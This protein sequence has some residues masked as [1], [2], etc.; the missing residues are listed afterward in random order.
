[1]PGHNTRSAPADV[2]TEEESAPG[3][4]L[5][6][7]A[8]ASRSALR[9]RAFRLEYV[10]IV[11]NSIEGIAAIAAGLLAGSVALVGFGLDSSVEVFASLAVVWELSGVDR[12]R[13]QTALRLIGTGYIVVALYVAWSAV[14]SL[15]S[16]HRPEASPLGMVLLAATVAVMAG[17]GVGKLR[18]GKALGSPT[19]E[20]DGRFSLVDA[21]LAA[22]VLVGLILTTLLGWWWSDAV[23]AVVISAFAL[24]EGIESWHGRE[25]GTPG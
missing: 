24:R 1:M 16:G 22:T 14:Q 12:R 6:P 10:T 5:D 18:V 11:W 20:A 17:L 25:H 7:R 2:R 13:E 9:R 23:L 21:S 8:T 4:P 3:H 19:V 15:A